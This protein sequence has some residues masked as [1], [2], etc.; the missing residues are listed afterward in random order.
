MN[1]LLNLVR[2]K[3]IKISSFICLLLMGCNIESENCWETDVVDHY[4]TVETQ[5]YT[6]S[7]PV[8]KIA[9]EG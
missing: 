4:K 6:V 7:E 3:M 8:Y 9:C 5:Y 2:L 1:M